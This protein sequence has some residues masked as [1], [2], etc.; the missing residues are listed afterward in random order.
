M[1]AGDFPLPHPPIA[2]GKGI[3]NHL[4]A[5]GDSFLMGAFLKAG[6]CGEAP[7]HRFGVQVW[8]HIGSWRRNPCLLASSSRWLLG[9]SA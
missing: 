9:G 3:K 4:Y 8:L 6:G 5:R 1:R 7:Q 2:W